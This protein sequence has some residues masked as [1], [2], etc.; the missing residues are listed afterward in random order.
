M[1]AQNK[2]NINSINV[3]YRNNYFHDKPNEDYIIA[4]D[5]NHI[6][7]LLDGVS[8]DRLNNQYPTPSPA[9]EASKIFA[10]TVYDFLI[11]NDYKNVL[12]LIKRSIILANIKLEEFNTINRFPFPAGT[13]G[14]VSVI[15]N[16]TFY[17][18]YIGDCFGRVI[19]NGNITCFSEEQT[20]LVRINKN[21]LTTNEIRFDI[22]NNIDHK[23]GYG[24][25]N[26]DKGALNFVRYGSF[27]IDDDSLI[28][29]STDGFEPY[30]NNINRYNIKKIL[31]AASPENIGDGRVDD[32]SIIIIGKIKND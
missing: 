13:V 5:K 21:N 2:I 3:T 24:V 19:S 11:K 26:G 18:S 22:C 6:Y 10:E 29:L 17:Y 23:Y 14:F 16:N 28:I 4:D 15:N 12:D 27:T 32:R 20:Y 9:L 30:L 31:H 7:I 25:Y 8:V 1:Q